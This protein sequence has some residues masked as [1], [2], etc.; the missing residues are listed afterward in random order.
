MNLPIFESLDEYPNQSNYLQ[1]SQGLNDMDMA[2]AEETEF[3]FSKFVAMKLPI[4]SNTN[5]WID[6]HEII[7]STNPNVLFPKA[8]QYYTENVMR[9]DINYNRLAEIGFWKMLQKFGMTAEAIKNSIVFVNDIT[10]SAFYRTDNNNGWAEII[11]TIPNN[12]QKLN[13]QWKDDEILPNTNAYTGDYLDDVS[14]FDDFDNKTFDFTNFREVIDFDNITY[15]DVNTNDEFEFNL[16]LL[17]Y[18][19][20]DG[21]DKL[22]GINFIDNFEVENTYFKLKNYKKITNDYKNIGY[23]FKFNMK[24]INNTATRLIVESLNLDTGSFWQNFDEYLGKM[25]Q[26]LSKF[27]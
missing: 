24:T 15:D 16:L 19:D 11:C 7:T 9:Q 22:H 12:A 21:V 20:K 2:Y 25:S 10:Q 1:L 5:L 8:L 27:D 17:F 13:I 23:Q 26:I 4:Y 14:Y 18:R 6:M 3:Y